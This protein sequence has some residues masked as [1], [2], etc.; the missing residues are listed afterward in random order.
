MD[1]QLGNQELQE[2]GPGVV[3]PMIGE[4]RAGRAW[5]GVALALAF[6]AHG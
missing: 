3:P 1:L 6:G 5:E 2:R 4:P